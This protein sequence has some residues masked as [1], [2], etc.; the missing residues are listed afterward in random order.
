M[1]IYGFVL[2]VIIAIPTV[3]LRLRNMLFQLSGIFFGLSTIYTTIFLPK[4]ISKEGKEEKTKRNKRYTK[5]DHLVATIGNAAFNV[6]G[7][8]HIMPAFVKILPGFFGI[9]GQPTRLQRFE[10]GHHLFNSISYICLAHLKGSSIFPSDRFFN[11][12]IDH[13]SFV[14]S[15]WVALKNIVAAHYYLWEK[16]WYTFSSEMASELC[17][18]H[19]RMDSISTGVVNGINRADCA[20]VPGSTNDDNFF[21]LLSYANLVG[22]FSIWVSEKIFTSSAVQIALLGVVGTI[23]ETMY[24]FPNVLHL[25]YGMRGVVLT[26]QS[27]V[28]LTVVL[29]S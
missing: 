28:F 29:M 4:L 3:S 2:I 26:I 21:L 24:F 6:R 22:P 11:I 10:A 13:L 15:S 8:L 17:R 9:I 1:S 5:I 7:C 27:C 16:L 20:V 19:N 14:I 23:L 18:P 25:S 12:F